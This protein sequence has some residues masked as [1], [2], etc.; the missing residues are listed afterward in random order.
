MNKD[1][2]L[3]VDDE[4]LIFDSIEDTLADDYQLFHAENGEAGLRLLA[5][6]Q[7]ILVILDIRMPVMDGFEFLKR[8]GVA[9]DDPYAVIVLSGHAAGS[10]I[11]ACYDMGITAFLR[12]PFNVFELKGLVKQCITAKKQ[13]RSLLHERQ[14]IRAIFDYSMDMIVVINQDL[15]VIDAN[16][17]AEMLFGYDILELKDVSLR[18]LLVQEEQCAALEAFLSTGAAFPEEMTVLSRSGELHSVLLKLAVLHDAAG[19]PIDTV[20]GENGPWD[21]AT[22]S[23]LLIRSGERM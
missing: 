23:I 5:E 8:V 18:Q 13:Y 3:V 19:N 6:L 12:K 15:Q 9:P 1:K 16:P 17:A 2:I 21:W 22:A 14:Y 11:G 4:Q 7:P 20:E 10:E